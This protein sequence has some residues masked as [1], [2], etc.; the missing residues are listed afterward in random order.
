MQSLKLFL[1][2][3][4]THSF[5]NRR[6][7]LSIILTTQT[8]RRKKI[9]YLITLQAIYLCWW[10]KKQHHQMASTFIR[11]RASLFHCDI[12]KEP[13]P[14]YSRCCAK[15]QY[16]DNRTP[17]KPIR[18]SRRHPSLVLLSFFFAPRD[19][20]RS[21]AVIAVSPRGGKWQSLKTV[22]VAALG[23]PL[24]SPARVFW[25]HSLGWTARNSSLA[26]VEAL[27]SASRWS[28]LCV[29]TG[30]FSFFFFSFFLL[31]P[32]SS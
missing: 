30:F 31:S 10:R 20:Y 2:S 3:I 1:A 18:N 21:M 22:R 12:L 8:N 11:R 26:M 9:F 32:S 7:M 14:Y 13:V 23:G 28:F 17:S 24:P 6:E 19:D 4:P 25:I 27:F 5:R 29:S 15:L 16:I